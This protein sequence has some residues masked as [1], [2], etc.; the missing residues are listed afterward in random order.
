[1]AVGD[2]LQAGGIGINTFAVSQIEAPF[3]GVKDSGYGNEG[4]VEGL[5][6]FMHPKFVHHIA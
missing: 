1:M 4:G 6:A 2:E 3:G 5:Q